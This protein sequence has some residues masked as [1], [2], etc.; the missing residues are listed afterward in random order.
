MRINIDKRGE[1]LAKKDYKK[2]KEYKEIRASLIAQLEEGGNNTP[3]FIGLVDDYMKL[4]VIKNELADD[5]EE[6]GVVCFYKNGKDQYGY[7]RNDSV[8]ELNKVSAQMLKILNQLKIQ[9]KEIVPQ[10]EDD[11]L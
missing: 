9:P 7:K 10:E 4:Y 8:G 11:E 1:K 3:F 2:T 5:I 6:R